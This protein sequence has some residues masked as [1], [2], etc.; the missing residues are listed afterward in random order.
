MCEAQGPTAGSLLN[1]EGSQR[2]NLGLVTFPHLVTWEEEQLCVGFS[3]LFGQ[4]AE[5]VVSNKL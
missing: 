4:K 3:C 1:G 5:K 2:P